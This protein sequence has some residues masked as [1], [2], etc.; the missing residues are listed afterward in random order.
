LVFSIFPAFE[1]ALLAFFGT[2]GLRVYLTNRVRPENATTQ[3]ILAET[4]ATIA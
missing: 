2:I 3:V 1:E 4:I